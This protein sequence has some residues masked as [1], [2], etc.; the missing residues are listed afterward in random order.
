M[1]RFLP[2]LLLLFIASGCAA[3]IYEIVWF[4]LLE[5]FIG[6][7]AI[8][9]GVL[10][11]SFMGGMCLGSLALPR[12][13]SPRFHPLRVYALLELGIGV[14][15]IAVY[16]GAPLAGKLYAA[17]IG[18]GLPGMLLR[19]AYC[20]ICLLPPAALMGATFP[21]MARWLEATPRGISWLGFFYGGNTAGAVTGCLL[22]G[23][24]L[25]RIHDALLATLVA[26]SLN[27]AAAGLAWALAAHAGYERETSN[28]GAPAA[29]SARIPPAVYIAIGLSGFTALGAEVVWTR[30]LSLMLGATVYTFSLI[31]AVF[32]FGL[33]AGSSVGALVARV[34]ERPRLALAVCQMLL[35]GCAAWAAYALAYTI[36]FLPV[37]TALS[38]GPWYLFQLDLMRCLWV[39]L[40]AACLWGASFPL[41]LAAA[42]RPGQDPGRLT[43]RIYA[44]NTLGA[45]LGAVAFS[46]A[47][48]PWIGTQNSQRLLMAACSLSGLA[49][50]ARRPFWP[51]RGPALAV[52]VGVVAVLAAGLGPIPWEVVGYGRKLLNMRGFA[53][54]E[55]VGEGR[56]AS[57]A[58]SR[59]S[60]G[61]P[62]FHISGRVEA[63]ADLQDLRMERMLGHLPA[64]MHSGPRSVLVVG[65][66]A[67]ITAGTFVLHPG[68]ERILIC[69]LEPLVPKVVSRYFAAENYGVLDDPRTRVVF[70]DARHFVF[71]TREKFDVITSDPVHPWIKGAATLYTREYFEMCRRRLNP[72][73]VVAQ[74]VPLY[75]ST[76][77]TVRS[78]FATFFEVFP[79]GVIWS[80]HMG[81]PGYDVVL[82]GWEGEGKIDVDALEARLA[83]AE[84]ARVNES[85][86]QV[87]LASALELLAT[88]GGQARDLREWL[89]GAPINDDRTLRL[90]YLAGMGLNSQGAEYIHDEMFDRRRFPGN[91][92]LVR[93]E[94]LPALRKALGL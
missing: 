73:G 22:A 42:A 64:L 57:V 9:L 1:R 46:I 54:V 82:V 78:E 5:L 70:D 61:T 48:V 91:L 6:S 44:A 7:S 62:Q 16:F 2:L 67:G 37:R 26:A 40:P 90:Q 52:A 60:D 35:A 18:Y 31:L 86:R 13:V 39:A 21:A 92:F 32:L 38:P 75:E 47:I 29:L 4:Q 80:N 15:G 69:E 77:D 19:G 33:S 25:L 36:P 51:V 30:L 11:G 85:L 89:K 17:A 41:A 84:Y 50:I 79:N 81:G 14:L 28:S 88:Y 71:T 55:Y 56:N 66:G 72:G 94:R 24:Y 74:W 3:L 8:S 27:L 59:M 53:G 43:A 93:E 87:R 20:A 12:Y 68:V 65:C 10:L 63:S 49:L 83:R 34:T 58:V 23:F 76:L 45:I